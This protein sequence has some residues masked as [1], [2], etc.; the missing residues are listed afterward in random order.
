MVESKG[1]GG[2]K[3]AGKAKRHVVDGR[4]TT[5]AETAAALGLD[6]QQIYNQMF[7]RQCGL[8]GVVNMFRDGM[9]LNGDRSDRHMVDGQW[10]TVKEQAAKLGKR[11]EVLH[12]WRVRH[13][14]AQG[15]PASLQ[16]TVDHYRY[17]GNCRG[18][19]PVQHRVDGRPMTVSEAAKRCGVSVNAV[20]QMMH[21]KKWSLAAVVRYYEKRGAKRAENEIMRILGF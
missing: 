10:T 1:S 14:D 5:V 11:P 6:A 12:N 7:I 18:N 21:K 9:I 8:Q 15:R 17:D 19:A 20:R 3:M 2:N 16:A 13:R 4:W